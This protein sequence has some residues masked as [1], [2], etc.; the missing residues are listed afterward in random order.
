VGYRFFACSAAKQQGVNGYVRNLPDGRVEV[1]AI[2]TSAQLNALR[3]ELK[4]GPRFSA[5]ENVSENAAELLP[6]YGSSFTIEQGDA[7]D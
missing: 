4:R 6:N 7:A 2:G 5:V 3:D 1:Y